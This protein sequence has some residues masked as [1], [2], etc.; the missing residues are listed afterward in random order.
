M[1]LFIQDTEL[2][3]INDDGIKDYVDDYHQ[4][5]P[6]ELTNNEK[7]ILKKLLRKIRDNGGSL[8]EE[9]NEENRSILLK[10]LKFV[11]RF[12]K[13]TRTQE[14]SDSFFQNWLEYLS[15][16]LKDEP[17]IVYMNMCKVAQDL[18][19]ISDFVGFSGGCVCNPVAKWDDDKM[20]IIFLPCEFKI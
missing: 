19:S 4:H 2:N 8:E 20:Q 12:L 7:K 11:F 9:W 13:E 6:N 18:K 16:E 14:E 15:E 17:S 3:F 10:L 1:C 5:R